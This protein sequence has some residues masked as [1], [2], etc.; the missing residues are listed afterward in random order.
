MEHATD[1][2]KYFGR[3]YTPGWIVEQLLAPVFAGSL[4]NVRICDPACGTGDFLVPLA[5]EVCQRAS[6]ASLYQKKLYLSTLQN[7]TGYD[8]DTRAVSE[9][10]KR[11][12]LVAEKY[13]GGTFPT[14]SWR[15]LEG[16]A[17]SL[18]EQDEGICDCV[19]GNPPYVRIQHM[20]KHRREQVK[21]GGW[22][23]FRGASDL[24]IIFLSW[25][26]AC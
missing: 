20:E 15:I 11:L 22:A 25:D 6:R 19:V 4:R 17:L 23:Y 8:V 26:S 12:S 7:L 24:Y 10:R 5:S 13:L 21:Q 3:V 14:C 18:W 2:T 1:T 9:C 16:D